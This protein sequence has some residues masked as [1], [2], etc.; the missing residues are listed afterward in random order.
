MPAVLSRAC[1]YG[2]A[3]DLPVAVW[4]ALRK[5]EGSANLILPFA[6]K[7]LAY[8]RG[9]QL[10]VVLYDGSGEVEFVLSCTKGPLGNYPVF[11]FTPKSAAQLNNVGNGI[12]DSMSQLVVSLL[13]AVPPQRVFS[14]FAIASVAEA[15]AQSHGI[16]RLVD[17]YYDAT[18]TFCTAET[19]SDPSVAIRSLAESGEF[20]IALRRA[21][22]THLAG[23]KALCKEFSETSPPFVLDDERAELE[24]KLLIENKQ[25][26]KR[27][28]TGTSACLV[29]TTRESENVTAV[30][31]VYAPLS[32]EGPR[33]RCTTYA[34]CLPRVEYRRRFSKQQVV[35]YVGNSNE[36]AAARRVYAK[37]GFQGIGSPAES[38]AVE[39]VEKWLEIGFEATTLG[40]W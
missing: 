25:A 30:T 40:Y 27:K 23:L 9:D 18:F 37:I 4:N 33:L 10:W 21:D 19:L 5:N 36:L 20:V 6:K 8:P 35:L 1:R 15:F 12:T 34:S 32:L 24:A 11:V 3:S 14:V 31:K 17:P 26:W 22:M 39:G 38:Y 2:H 16:Q 28:K 7:A 29:A 13:E